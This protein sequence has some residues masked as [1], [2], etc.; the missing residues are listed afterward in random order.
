MELIFDV[1]GK[2]GGAIASFYADHPLA[3]ALV[4]IV[5]IGVFWKLMGWDK[6]PDFSDQR[7]VAKN[8]L[9]VLMGWAIAVPILDFLS[10]FS[11]C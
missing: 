4:T 6:T 5:A 3:A 2:I 9:L 8:G 11:Q 1:L 10:H 7:K